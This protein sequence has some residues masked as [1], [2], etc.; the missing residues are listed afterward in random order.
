MDRGFHHD[1]T[2]ALLCPTS[3]DWDDPAFASL[4]HAHFHDSSLFFSVRDQLRSGELTIPG[5]QWPIFIWA[6]QKYDPED[7]WKGLLKGRLL[8]SVSFHIFKF[9]VLNHFSGVQTRIHFTELRRERAQGHSLWKCTYTWN[10]KRNSCLNCLYRNSGKSL[11]YIGHYL[12][13][14]R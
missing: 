7:P 9:F 2:G 11:Q 13:Q 8:V 6:D 14:S 10:D 4:V 12:K 1:T 5:D 3:L